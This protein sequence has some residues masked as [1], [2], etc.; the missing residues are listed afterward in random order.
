MEKTA[1]TKQNKGYTLVEIIIVIVLIGLLATVAGSSISLVFSSE[2]KKCANNTSALIS[3]AKVSALSREGNV[4]V[5]IY[6]DGG[7][8]VGAYYENGAEISREKLGGSRVNF[9]YMYKNGQN[10]VNVNLTS[11]PLYISFNKGTGSLKTIGE[12]SLA[13]LGSASGAEAAPAEIIITSGSRTLVITF[14][15]STG[16]HAITL[17]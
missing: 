12:A 4:G 11:T 1:S 14:V 13:E 17:R 15:E 7:N 5:K 3:K 6:R 10:E 2:A 16:Q 9:N 8:I